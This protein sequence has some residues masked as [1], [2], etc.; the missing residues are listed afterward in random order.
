MKAARIEVLAGG[1][2]CAMLISFCARADEGEWLRHCHGWPSD[3]LMSNGLE[4]QNLPM[5]SGYG[6]WTGGCMHEKGIS[7][8]AKIAGCSGLIGMHKFDGMKLADVYFNRG[9]AYHNT[10]QLDLAIADYSHALAA[11][12]HFPEAL[13]ARGQA[14]ST[15]GRYDLA[16]ADLDEAIREAPKF[17]TA[18]N[19]RCWTRAIW[20]KDLEAALADC[21]E[22]LRLAP[23][24][25]AFMDSRGLVRFRMGDYA[26]ALDE[27]EAAHK[28]NPQSA[29]S[30]YMRGL[31]KLRLGRADEA[32]ADL[33]AAAVI[34]PKVAETYA[35]LDVK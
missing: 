27:Y 25:A 20:N 10:D 21:N 6:P 14:Y 7:F 33:A 22:A 24:M 15:A 29:S 12:R 23:T 5:T 1:I 16:L 31:T 19:N 26:G 28:A 11:F 17:A 2:A 4:C 9:M 34:D 35:R 8:D 13:N 18:F 3:K 32:N 30:L